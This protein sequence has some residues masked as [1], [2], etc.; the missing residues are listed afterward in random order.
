M[1]LLSTLRNRL[2]GRREAPAEAASQA[3]D[4]PSTTDSSPTGGST[5]DAT[6]A[7]TEAATAPDLS[8]RQ[9]RAAS[10]LLDDERLRG[11]LTDDEYQ[12][13]LDWALAAADSLALS[14]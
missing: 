9:E 13:L 2:F 7:P 8:G 3:G 10:R 14:T 6:Q 5:M 11:D 4:A 1:S 12:P